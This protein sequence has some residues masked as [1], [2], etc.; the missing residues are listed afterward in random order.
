MSQV[1]YPFGPGVPAS[2]NGI[3][4]KSY[5]AVEF[6]PTEVGGEYQEIR[7]INGDL[8]IVTNAQYNETL[9]LT[10]LAAGAWGQVLTSAPSFAMVL[11]ASGT[12]TR[13]TAAAIGGPTLTAITFIQTPFNVGQAPGSTVDSFQ[14]SSAL[15]P[16]TTPAWAI[17]SQGW[18][19]TAQPA[20]PGG[21]LTLTSGQP[22]MGAD[23]VLTSAIYYTP[24]Q[25]AYLP[26]FDSALWL[27]VPFTEQTLTMT[28]A[29]NVSGSNYDIFGFLV[30]N[31][32]TIGTGPAWSSTT[33]R[34]AGAG[35]TQLS[36]VNGIW[37]NTVSV[38]CWNNGVSNVIAAGQATYL[39]SINCVANAQ[40]TMNFK[41][42]AAAGGTNNVLGLYNAYN[43]IVIKSSEVTSTNTSSYAVAT[44]RPLGNS[45]SNR[46]TFIDGLQQSPI[47]VELTIV[48]GLTANASNPLIGTDLDGIIAQPGRRTSAFLTTFAPSGEIDVPGFVKETFAPLLGQHFLQAMEFAA[49]AV[50]YTAYMG[51]GQYQL[52]LSMEM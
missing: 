31:T 22:V 13:Y 45:T 52:L 38:T 9:A 17:N 21:R 23:V 11:K 27:S 39:G 51:S 12:I 42:V 44:W 6:N 35:T 19:R 28:A 49:G 32:F 15:V 2:Q 25:T 46:I 40:V 33:V 10:P 37:T 47:D 30:G 3:I 5:P 8:W 34:G 36:Q 48:L 4:Q 50:T 1:F 41:P 14:V 18:P 16:S 24:Y 20:R 7:E 29:R 43:R 26:I